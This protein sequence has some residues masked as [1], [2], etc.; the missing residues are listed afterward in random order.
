MLR[1][2]QTSV[3]KLQSNLVNMDTEQGCALKGKLKGAQCSTS[4]QGGRGE[5]RCLNLTSYCVSVLRVL[6][7]VRGCSHLRAKVR[8]QGPAGSARTQPCC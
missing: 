5:G 1:N 4:G 8:C 7:R 3:I 2:I 6:T